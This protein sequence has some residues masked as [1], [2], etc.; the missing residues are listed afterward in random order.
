VPTDQGRH[1][2]GEPFSRFEALLN[3]HWLAHGSSWKLCESLPER[4]S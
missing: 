2:T 1:L 3:V 4:R